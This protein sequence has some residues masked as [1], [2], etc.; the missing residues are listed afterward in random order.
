MEI[1]KDVIG[2]EG[3]YQISNT[4][5]IKRIGAYT[6][7]TGKTW[8][9]ERIL[10]LAVKTKGYMYVQLSKNGKTSSKYVHRLVAG[11]LISNPENKPTVNHKNGNKADNSVENLEWT[12]Y[13]ENNVHSVR[14]LGN[15]N[16]MEYVI[17]TCDTA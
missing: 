11:A 8:C 9:S 15:D 3:I 2:Y 12:T 5:K 6:N 7:Q 16:Q 13:T 1:W 17:K 4:G 14:I 10:K